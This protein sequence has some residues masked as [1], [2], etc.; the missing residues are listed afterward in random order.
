MSDLPLKLA[1]RGQLAAEDGR[2]LVKKLRNEE[3]GEVGSWMIMAAGL[4][5]AA[6]AAIA[7]IG[8]WINTKATAITG[9]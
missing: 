6:A 5:A 9:N 2:N 1:V 7:L 3:R 4:A 8:P